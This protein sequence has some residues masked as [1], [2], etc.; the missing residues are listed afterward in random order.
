MIF[1]LSSFIISLTVLLPSSCSFWTC[2]GVQCHIDHTSA[3]VCSIWHCAHGLDKHINILAV[4]E[5]SKIR[6]CWIYFDFN[7]NQVQCCL[8]SI[9]FVIICMN[10]CICIHVYIHKRK[11]IYICIFTYIHIYIYT[12]VYVYLYIHMY[13]YIYR[14]VFVCVCIHIHVYSYI[15]TH[16]HIYIYIYIYIHIYIYTYI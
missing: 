2:A 11:Y 8:G 9:F 1:V 3:D 12:H 4:S 14:D 10:W 13:I 16:T 6:I 5:M 7:D 15:Y